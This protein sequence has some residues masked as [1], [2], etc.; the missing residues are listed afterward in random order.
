MSQEVLAGLVGKSDSWIRALESG[1]QDMPKMPI[2]LKLAEA[3]RVR[4]L[5]QLTGGQAIEVEQFTGPGHVRLPAVRAAV[6]QYPFVTDRP[7]PSLAHIK[8]RLAQAWAARH[9]SP[10]HRDVVGAL[11]PALIQDTQLAVCQ[12]ATAAKRRSA[13]ALLAEVYS[14]SQFFVAYQP[15]GDLLWRVAE[16]GMVAAHDSADLHAIGLA[17]WLTSQA[18]RD[19]GDW[20]AADDVN[21]GAMR[22]LEPRV[23][24]APTPVLAIWGALQFEAGYTAARRGEIGTAWRYWDAASRVANRLPEDYYHPATSFSRAIMSAHA[25]TVAVELHQGS[26]SVR[27]A[28]ASEAVSIPSLPRRARHKVEQARAF[29][30]DRQPEAAVATLDAAYEVAPETVAYNSYARRILLEELDAKVP[31]RREKA[32]LTASKIGLLTA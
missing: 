10:N 28:Q 13:Q 15:A 8:A 32:A 25:V 7:A 16:R 19:A 20:D 12:A 23:S 1:T 29:Y 22:F 9:A 31:S 26:E 14:L 11:L 24:K 4:D 5:S 30:L 18:H 27:Q 6:N 17:S 2:L 3:L 21:L